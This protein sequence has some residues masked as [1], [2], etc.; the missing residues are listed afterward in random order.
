MIGFSS[1]APIKQYRLQQIHSVNVW[2]SGF[3][4]IYALQDIEFDQSQD[5]YSIPAVFGKAAA[6]RIS[7]F[8]HFLSAACVILAGYYGHF[9]WLY[10][11]GI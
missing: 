11:I 3:D 5:L 1:P 4:V 10:W 2:V 8:L 7:S 6:L 9:H